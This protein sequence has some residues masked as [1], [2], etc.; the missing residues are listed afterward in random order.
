VQQLLDKRI[1]QYAGIS[2]KDTYWFIQMTVHPGLYRTYA[3]TFPVA[4][5]QIGEGNLFAEISSLHS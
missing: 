5:L 2:K 3:V 4:G 1:V